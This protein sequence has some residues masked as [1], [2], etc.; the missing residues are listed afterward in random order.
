MNLSTEGASRYPATDVAE[1]RYRHNR[2]EVWELDERSRLAC[3]G[4]PAEHRRA[5][6]AQSSVAAP[7]FPD[8]LRDSVV[9]LNGPAVCALDL[10]ARQLGKITHRLLRGFLIQT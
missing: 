6:P 3:A 9:S 10:V 4:V 1:H 8:L 2:A 5:E 7:E